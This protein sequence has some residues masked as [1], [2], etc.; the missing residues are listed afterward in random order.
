MI[1]KFTQEELEQ[2]KQELAQLSGI[3][4]SENVFMDL[5]SEFCRD[6]LNKLPG[7]KIKF[8]K[9]SIINKGW[10]TKVCEVD[11]YECGKIGYS[12]IECMHKLI[13]V[14]FGCYS[15][16]KRNDENYVFNKDLFPV[17]YVQEARDMYKEIMDVVKKHL[18]PYQEEK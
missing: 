4:I 8:K 13:K 16:S 2:I 15:K 12:V 9:G 6:V 17:K 3:S 14:T 5:D 11:R 1:E 10:S 7:V 18:K